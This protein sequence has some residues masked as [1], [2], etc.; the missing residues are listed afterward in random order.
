MKQIP[1]RG[2]VSVR[3]HQVQSLG[4]TGARDLFTLDVRRYVPCI[5]EPVACHQ[6]GGCYSLFW[7][8]ANYFS[9]LSEWQRS[10]FPC[11]IW[12]YVSVYSPFLLQSFPSCFLLFSSNP[13][14]FAC[15]NFFPR[16]PH[17]FSY[18]PQQHL[19]Q[20]SE[21]YYFHLRMWTAN[22]HKYCD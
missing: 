7:S 9:I 16:S 5:V 20:Q 11:R 3:R 6:L 10:L 21:T 8:L 1:Y 2:P 15:L 13:S 18:I 14:L 12:S 22:F 17:F 19:R 4:R